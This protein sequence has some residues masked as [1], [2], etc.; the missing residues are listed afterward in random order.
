M[1]G[2]MEMIVISFYTVS[3]GVKMHSAIFLIM[4]SAKLKLVGN[5]LCSVEWKYVLSVSA[6]ISWLVLL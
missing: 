2:K 5:I 3:L 4:P 1:I 6:K